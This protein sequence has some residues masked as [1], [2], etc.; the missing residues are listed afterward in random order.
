MAFGSFCPLLDAWVPGA[1]LAAPWLALAS[2]RD[3]A[4]FAFGVFFATFVTLLF[5][6]A[7]YAV[8]ADI[9]RFYRW[10]WTGVKQPPVG[11]GASE[12]SDYGESHEG[13]VPGLSGRRNPLWDPAE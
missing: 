12:Q 6:P 8:G 2:Q 1:A 13:H 4:V 11:H 3:Q 5:V 9:S 10:A 7:M